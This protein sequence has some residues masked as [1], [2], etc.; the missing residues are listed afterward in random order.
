MRLDEVIDALRPFADPRY[1]HI[2]VTAVDEVT[3]TASRLVWE[4]DQLRKDPESARVTKLAVGLKGDAIVI[5][6][7]G[8]ETVEPSF[9]VLDTAV[10]R[11]MAR[12]LVE[13]A[14]SIDA[15]VAGQS[16]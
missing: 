14:D 2:K 4:Y 9:V 3:M 15:R 11:S 10:A 12:G 1:P 13:L 5:V 16:H 8:N 6:S 7:E